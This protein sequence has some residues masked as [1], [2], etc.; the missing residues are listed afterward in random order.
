MYAFVDVQ[1]YQIVGTGSSV[2]EAKADYIK[3]LGSENIEVTNDNPDVVTKTVEVTVSDVA[4]AVVGGNTK[5]YIKTDNGTFI[6]DITLSSDLPFV[7]SGDKAVVTIKTSTEE[8][9]A[10]ISEEIVGFKLK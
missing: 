5:Y 6:V 9:S 3:K 1:Q 4:T 10:D 7:S 2:D 8:T